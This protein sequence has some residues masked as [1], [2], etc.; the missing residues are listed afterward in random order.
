MNLS[1]VADAVKQGGGSLLIIVFRAT[2]YLSE[3]NKSVNIV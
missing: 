3:S 2:V 1:A